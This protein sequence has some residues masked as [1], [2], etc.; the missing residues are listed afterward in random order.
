MLENE[1]YDVIFINETHQ[2]E[3]YLQNLFI[4]VKHYDLIIN[5]HNPSKWHGVMMLIKMSLKYT[6]VDCDPI[7]QIRARADCNSSH[8]SCGRI[9][10]VNI[11]G[12]III[13]VYTPNSG[14]KTRLKNTIT[15]SIN[16]TLHSPIYYIISKMTK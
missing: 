4:D 14:I 11:D 16:G 13:G 3:T 7:M 8:P 10:C 5:S 12:I 6:R 1:D 2:S 15:A 9:V